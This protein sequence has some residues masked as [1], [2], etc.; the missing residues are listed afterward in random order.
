MTNKELLENVIIDC[1][2]YG[3]DKAT[4]DKET[5]ESIKKELEEKEKQDKILKL[6]V[7]KQIDVKLVVWA[8]V[9]VEA[10]NVKVRAEKDYWWRE[11][12]TQDEFDLIKEWLEK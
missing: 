5:L 3:K 4:I 10:Y 8:G 12:L 1:E 6:I 9:N 11:E 7:E 2:Y